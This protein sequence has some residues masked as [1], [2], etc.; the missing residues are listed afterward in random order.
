GRQP[1]FGGDRN[2]V[3]ATL[4]VERLVGQR[5][6]A[7]WRN[8]VGPRRRGRKGRRPV[9]LDDAADRGH[10]RATVA[11]GGRARYIVRIVKRNLPGS[12]IERARRAV[13]KTRARHR[14][15]AAA[16]RGA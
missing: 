11:D 8:V 3:A 15:T 6:G 10:T 5:L 7:R 2:H 4:G 1:Y 12:G 14:R 13:P 9:P 16:A